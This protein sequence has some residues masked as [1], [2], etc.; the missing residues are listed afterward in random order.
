MV[1]AAATLGMC[2]V[3][4]WVPHAGAAG[5]DRLPDVLA[6]IEAA[7]GGRLGVAVLDTASGIHVGYR[8]GER[9]ALCS[10]FK[11]LLAAAV[12]ARVDAGRESLGRRISFQ[13]GDLVPYSPRTGPGAGGEGLSVEALADAAVTLSDNTAANLLLATLGGPEGLTRF[14]RSVGDPMTRLDRIEPALNEARPGDPRDTTTPGAMV[15]SMESLLLGPALSAA[16]RMRLID[17]MVACATGRARLRAGL[18]VHWRA[19]D[20]TGSGERGTAND[21]AIVWPPGR[22]PILIAAY[23]TE[24]AVEAAR[25][26]ATLAA[27]ARA[28]AEFV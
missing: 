6:G 22:D 28:V 24:C 15:S 26:D 3:G 1:G 16:S 9:F 18:P 25:R 17:W 27:V 8:A 12:L 20:K 4:G 11:L 19:G 5:L 21:V 10:T 2:G 23:L 13:A 7:S 14:V